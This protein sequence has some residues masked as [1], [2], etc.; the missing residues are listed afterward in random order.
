MRI[1]ISDKY[2]L[3]F[4]LLFSFFITDFFSWLHSPGI[5]KGNKVN[6][7]PDAYTRIGLFIGNRPYFLST[8][9]NML[10]NG[11]ITGDNLIFVIHW[12]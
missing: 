4:I 6:Q 10:S 8:V 9:S 1:I 2:F 3:T 11:I 5:K 7:V 12:V